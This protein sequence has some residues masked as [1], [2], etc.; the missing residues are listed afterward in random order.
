LLFAAAH[1]MGDLL[2]VRAV[3]EAGAA[4][5]SQIT[6]PVLDVETLEKL[7]GTFYASPVP[8]AARH[9]KSTAAD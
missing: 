7:I 4:L 8:E 3:R 1:T 2:D 5:L 9:A 6:Q